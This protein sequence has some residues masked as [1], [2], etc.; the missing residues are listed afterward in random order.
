MFTL[1]DNKVIRAGDNYEYD[2][3]E[4]VEFAGMWFKDSLKLDCLNNAGVDNWDW[5]GDAM[6]E[7]AK[8]LEGMGLTA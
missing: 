4:F 2:L 7:Y 1:K 6:Q 3:A 8:E 5:H